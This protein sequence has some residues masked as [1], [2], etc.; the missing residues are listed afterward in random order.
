M[1]STEPEKIDEPLSEADL[2]EVEFA[3]RMLQEA[4]AE[5]GAVEIEEGETW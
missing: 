1:D 3:E 4:I 2:R 5:G